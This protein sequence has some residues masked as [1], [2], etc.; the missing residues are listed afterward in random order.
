MHF[1]ACTYMQTRYVHALHAQPMRRTRAVHTLYV[2][3]PCSAHIMCA[4]SVQ[5]THVCRIRAVHT[6]CVQNPCSAHIMR[7]E[8]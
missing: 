2:Q 6:L 1:Y 8:F 4:A 7:A 3:N 5:C